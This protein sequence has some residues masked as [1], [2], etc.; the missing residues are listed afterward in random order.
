MQAP[1]YF[2]VL[3]RGNR[4]DVKQGETIVSSPARRGSPRGP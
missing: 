4:W 2:V 1:S 3:Q